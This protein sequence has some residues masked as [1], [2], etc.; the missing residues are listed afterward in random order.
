M[1]I[2]NMLTNEK[3]NVFTQAEYTGQHNKM[4][5]R[6]PWQ[7][8]NYY[9]DQHAEWPYAMRESDYSTPISY[10]PHHPGT[11]M[12]NEYVAI[13]TR[14]RAVRLVLALQTWKLEHGS[15]PKTI[16]EP[17]RHLPGSTSGRSVFGRTVPLFPRRSQ[18]PPA[19]AAEGLLSPREVRRRYALRLVCSKSCRMQPKR[20]TTSSC[21]TRL[22]PTTGRTTPCAPRFGVRCLGSRLAVPDPVGEF[23]R[24]L[25]RR[26]HKRPVRVVAH[27]KKLGTKT[28]I[29]CRSPV[30]YRSVH[31]PML[32]SA[33]SR[34]ARGFKKR[35]L[36][37]T[38]PR[39]DATRTD[40]V[41]GSLFDISQ[42]V[43][44]RRRTRCARPPLSLP[45]I[46]SSPC[47]RQSPQIVP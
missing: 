42:F 2:L 3:L 47:L 10:G 7:Q 11:E 25:V 37:R 46:I 40:H 6:P 5:Q 35:P 20:K 18:T 28:S 43:P 16:D 38:P 15:L 32:V 45:L 27:R 39:R 21:D 36:A 1:R 24:M 19:L 8:E 23:P 14:R 22:S 13:E 41:A 34:I 4:I 26:P 44:T 17:G 31:S 29:E 9:D 33:A 30:V 12:L